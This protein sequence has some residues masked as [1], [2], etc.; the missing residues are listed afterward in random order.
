MVMSTKIQV[1]LDHMFYFILHLTSPCHRSSLK[2]KEKK[3][4]P[5]YTCTR[6]MKMI[7][8]IKYIISFD[9][10]TRLTP[11]FAQFTSYVYHR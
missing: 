8:Y 5:K 4:D 10:I 1:N 7:S 6:V 2:Q 9:L 3:L 11:L